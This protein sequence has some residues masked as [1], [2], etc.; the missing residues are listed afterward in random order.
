MGYDIRLRI[1]V[2]TPHR[3]LQR[4]QALAGEALRN[5]DGAARNS[6]MPK[7]TKERTEVISPGGLFNPVTLCM[8]RRVYRKMI[9]LRT[10][11]CRVD[12]VSWRRQL[13][14]RL[15][16]FTRLTTSRQ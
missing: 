7:E 14:D 3:P 15:F 4:R 8:M 11:T 9:K 2:N 13:L 1:V 12:R 16:S 5:I 10:R 6:P